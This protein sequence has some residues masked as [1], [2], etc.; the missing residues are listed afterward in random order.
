MTQ[1]PKP[2]QDYIDL[3][4][5]GEIKTCNEQKLLVKMV[6]DV[7]ASEELVFDISQIE[8]YLSYQ[9]YFPYRLF[10]W[11][12][13]CFVLHNCIFTTDDEPRWDTLFV[14]M[15][16]GGGKNGYLSFEDFCLITD[17]NGI[18]F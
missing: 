12:I 8:K 9:K 11:E 7:F 3:V 16:R 15:G 6:E 5:N 17:T 13:F 14:L 4:K 10:F 18:I 2:I 1:I